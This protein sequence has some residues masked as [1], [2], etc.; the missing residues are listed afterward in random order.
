[1]IDPLQSRR[2]TLAAIITAARAGS[3]AHASA[4]FTA[5]GFDRLTDDPDALAVK[6]R[7]LKDQALRATPPNRPALF[8]A[9]AQAYRR[10]N[11][12]RPQPYT[13]INEASLLLLAGKRDQA[14]EI[15]TALLN[16]MANGAAIAETPYYI[17]A[18]R[19]EAH[20]ICGAT[21]DAKRGISAAF[22]CDP[23]GWA[24]HASTLRQFGLLLDALHTDS[25]WLD[26]FRPPASLSFAGHLAVAASQSDDLRRQ[27]DT[28]LDETRIGFGYG[29]LAAGADIVVAEALLA[30]DI[31]LHVILPTS[32]ETF[33]AQSVAPYDPEWRARFDACIEH[34]S[35]IQCVTSVSGAYEP[36]AT[37]LAADVA[38][39]AA[40]LNAR[41]LEAHAAQLLVV[42]DGSGAFG[43][44]V[45]TGYLGER[46]AADA[47]QRLIVMPRSAPIIASGVRM[48]REGRPDRRLLALLMI[49]LTG[50]D[51]L[52]DGTF[53]LR[54]DSLIRPL[55]AAAR[56]FTAQPDLTLS[57][58][59]SRILAFSSP[60]TAWDYAVALQCAAPTAL[61]LRLAAH[62]AVVHQF[63]APPALNGRGIAELNMVSAAALPGVTT[64]SDTLAAALAI[65]R[66]D[67]IWAEHI[68]EA[69]A[70]KLYALSPR[71]PQSEN[72]LL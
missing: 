58:G 11:Q 42:D 45:A 57:Y 7:L 15:A 65:N 43:T 40:V 69:G 63:D 19:A 2:P 68:G 12:L 48:D 33:V 55:D 29:A 52:D 71:E 47:Q 46:W 20:L 62:Y 49:N 66:A 24:N 34:A 10:S 53:A 39:G 60:E 28:F 17:E 37:K 14:I 25:S 72:E 32:I 38:M 27:V 61:A 6:G 41:Q 44:G 21:P 50:L 9:A 35:T 8:E 1:M 4:M 22:A 26:T 64:V 51:D 13:Q 16:S 59:N 31:D 36:L 70:L 18:T 54:I 3:L 23:D 30:R 67:S 5:G 56:N